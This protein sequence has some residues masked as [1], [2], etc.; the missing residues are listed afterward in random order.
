MSDSNGGGGMQVCIF[1]QNLLFSSGYFSENT[2]EI[3]VRSGN[4]K[5]ERKV[6]NVGHKFGPN[7]FTYPWF[8]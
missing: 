1:V 8:T 6:V 2:E 3:L 7:W 4:D 5:S